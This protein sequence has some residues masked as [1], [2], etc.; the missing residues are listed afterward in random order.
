MDSSASTLEPLLAF[1]AYSMS[2]LEST[3][4]KVP[5][6]AVL[7]RYVRSSHQ[8]DPGRTLLELILIVF[9]IRTLLQSRTRTD[10]SGKNFIKFNEK[11]IDELVDEWTP[12][13]LAQPLSEW[14]QKDLASVP[15]ISGANGPKAKILSTGKTVTNL[16]SFNF[17]GLAGNEQIKQHAIDTL[18][19]YGL[20]SCG[21]P[22]FY[23]TL[24][25]HLDLERDI[26]EFLGTEASILCSQGFSTISSVIPAFCKREDFIVADRAVNFSIQ[27]GIQISRSTV[28]WYD[29][30]DL[31]SLEDALQSVEKERKKRKMP[32]TRRFIIT[33]GIFERDGEMVDLPK[34]IELKLKYKYRLILDE[35]ISFGTVGRTGRGLTELYNVPASQIDMLIGSVANGLCSG[36]G[37]CAGSMNVVDHQRIN[38]PSFVYS[39]S[40]P[41]LLATTASAAITHLRNTPSVLT[42]LQENIRTLRSVL[43]KANGITVLGHPA[44]P[45]VHFQ[46]RSSQGGSYEGESRVLQEIVED[47]LAQGVL[48][49]R[50]KHL[51]G[52]ELIEMPPTIRIAVTSAMTKKEVE[53]A[54]G[55]VKTSIAR[56]LGKRR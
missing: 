8:N 23:G 17:T 21:P 29:H 43:D 27:K 28:R 35:S 4:Y 10:R 15:V 14:E 55:V 19:K 50:A 24:D 7:A 45:I 26:A 38:A 36:G 11:E 40:M 53:K 51:K 3:F 9:A 41:A 5:G 30:N 56:V 46:L 49:T 42:M 33:E 16:A 18:R 25:V 2:K 47:A 48:L 12:E 34:I 1:F 44:S 37:F 6:S 31:K 22:G 52:Q 32:L 54:A 39:A 20:G 13:P